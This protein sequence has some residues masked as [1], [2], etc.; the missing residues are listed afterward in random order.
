M[1]KIDKLLEIVKSADASDLHLV[2]GTAPLVRVHGKLQRTRHRD[3]SDDEVKRLVYEILTD[4]QIRR[5]EKSGDLDLAYGVEGL[6]R[7][8]VNIYKTYAGIGGAIR[9]IPQQPP[10][11]R[12]LGFSEAVCDLAESSAGLIL[13]TGPTNSGKTTTLAAM[14]EH[15]N[16]NSSRH[17]ITL[18]DPVEYIHTNKNSLISQRQIG[19]HSES[20][21]RGLRA[22]LREDP[23][24]ILVG[25][26][27]D[28]ETIAMAITAAEVGL[29]VMGTLH[30][31]S[32]S[33]SVDRVIE[34]FPVEQQ[35]QIRVMLADSLRGIVSQQLPRRADG[36]G[37]V[38]A[39][40]LLVR[41]TSI[42]SMIREQK[43]YQIPTAIQ[44]GRKQGMQLMDTH[45]QELVESGQIT[46]EES[47]KCAADPSKFKD[48]AAMAGRQKVTA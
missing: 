13:V 25:E 28:L 10:D 38:A 34:V 26:M 7:F 22:A 2:A 46:P 4:E 15:M 27:R 35:Q 47:M 42:A 44:T 33:A 5:F 17:I 43:T 24:V 11:L 31:R 41:T 16:S 45:L 1:P 23:D 6:G 8:R 9:I 12:A 14:V 29:L 30:T 36:R 39:Y 40:E 20:F 3:L 37:R 19:L 32:A 21:A 48:A 18:E